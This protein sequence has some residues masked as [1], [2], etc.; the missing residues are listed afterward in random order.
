[1]FIE[2]EADKK[3]VE[4]TISESE[5]PPAGDTTP[6][7]FSLNEKGAIVETAEGEEPT[8]EEKKTLTHVGEWL[9]ARIWLVAFVELCERFTYYG[10]QGLFQNYVSHKHTKEPNRGLG[11]GH[12][13]ATGL[14][15]FFQFFCYLTPILGAIIADQYLG[16]YKTILIFCGVYVVG[17]GILTLTSLP[18]TMYHGD[19]GVIGYV[20]SLIGMLHSI[21]S[22]SLKYS[23][24]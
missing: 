24:W 7:E 9:P 21:L 23:Q 18:S 4:R 12:A 14:G 8:E 15:T 5:T 13:A 16:R 22:P 6:P 19:A 1:V 20:I 11:L 17:L 3:D 2:S 10:M